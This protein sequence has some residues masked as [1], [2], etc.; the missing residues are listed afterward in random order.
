M[1]YD[2][3]TPQ[4]VDPNESDEER[5][6]REDREARE[7]EARDADKGDGPSSHETSGRSPADEV[8]ATYD[9]QPTTTPTDPGDQPSE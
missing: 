3:N 5:A 8:A 2:P 9:D 6:G 1:T 7:R 4:P